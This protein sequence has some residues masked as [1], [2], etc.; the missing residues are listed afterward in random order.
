MG[1]V[2]N[3]G[4]PA[5][6]ERPVHMVRIPAFHI[7]ETAVTNS[8]FATFVEATRYV[9]DAERYGSSAVFH[10]VVSAPRVDMFGQAAGAPWWTNVR[11]ADWRHPEGSTSTIADR[12]DH[13]VVHVSWL[14]AQ[15]YSRWAGKRLATEAEWEFAARG[16][17]AG[18]RFAWG[19]ELTPDGRWMC[20]IWQGD[21][22][23][24][25]IGEDG[26]LSTAPVKG[27]RPNGYGL[28]NMAGN[29]WEWCGDWFSPDYHTPYRQPMTRM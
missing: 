16:G 11:S 2:F 4:Y 26:Y 8:Q 7:D 15:A 3:E 19:N 10:L 28:W 21:F 17:L 22:P 9:T 25:N 27:Y 29:V 13:P 14:D 5:D 24:H 12:Q 6:G 20:N 23:R 1:D 18:K